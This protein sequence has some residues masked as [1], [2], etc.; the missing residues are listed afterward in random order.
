MT[1]QRWLTDAD[2][3]AGSQSGSIWWHYLVVIV[4]DNL[5]YTRNATMWVTGWSQ[6]DSAPHAGDEDIVVSAALATN[7][8]CVMGALFQVNDGRVILCVYGCVVVSICVLLWISSRDGSLL[9][10]KRI[11]DL[12]YFVC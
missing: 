9:S 10:K 4:P 11:K 2:F 5:K 8:G 12:R 1:S 7:L 6:G 3:S